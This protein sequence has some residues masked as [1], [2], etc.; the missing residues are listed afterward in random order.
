MEIAFIA[1]TKTVEMFIILLLGVILAKVGILDENTTKK[2]GNV[3][4]FLVVPCIIIS[5]YQIDF[6]TELMQGWLWTIGLA[7]FIFVFAILFSRAILSFGKCRD[8]DIERL[9]IIYPDS[10]YIGLPLVSALFGA[11]GIFYVM[12]FNTVF[13][14]FLWTQ[15]VSL[16]NKKQSF[17]AVVRN[18]CTPAIIAVIFGII[19]FLG[20][21]R[22][23]EILNSP[24]DAI[25]SMNMPLAMLVAGATVSSNSVKDI[26]KDKRIYYI[27]FLILFALPLLFMLICGALPIPTLPYFVV[28]IMCACPAGTS[29][30]LFALRYDRD[31]RYASQILAFTTVLCII[32]IPVI[33][34]IQGLIFG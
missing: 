7:I 3:L 17:K 4:L 25:A 19:L 22:L 2:L 23:P 32:T 33:L 18:L 1:F 5:N 16:M 10:G 12:A 31:S 26:L 11:E 34:M 6:S 21:I 30:M 9:S 28:L 15:G 20:Q 14:I 29:A 24:I 13:N 27:S 8:K